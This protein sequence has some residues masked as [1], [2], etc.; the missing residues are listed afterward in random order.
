MEEM[1]WY[2]WWIGIE[3]RS[4]VGNESLDIEGRG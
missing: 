2:V 1:R 4:V 3:T